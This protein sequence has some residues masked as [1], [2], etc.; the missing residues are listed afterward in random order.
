MGIA[1]I[2]LVGFAIFAFFIMCYSVCE[3]KE[4]RQ[5][6]I[7]DDPNAD[8]KEKEA[9]LKQ[10]EVEK[11]IG[12]L[13]N[14]GNTMIR[15]KV[16]IQVKLLGVYGTYQDTTDNAC[17]LI[18]FKDRLAYIDQLDM[19]VK[20]SVPLEKIINVQW[21]VTEKMT[22]YLVIDCKDPMTETERSI[23]FSP[24]RNWKDDEF[25]NNII[26]ARN[27]CLASTK[28]VNKVNEEIH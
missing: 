13:L 10:R 7:L 8:P 18:L 24:T 4:E 28:D 16:S 2:L 11:I 6:V 27:K 25:V 26:V 20:F 23:V 22:Y 15:N 3:K 21:D 14:G 1:V 12:D 17:L 5:Q 19:K 9:I